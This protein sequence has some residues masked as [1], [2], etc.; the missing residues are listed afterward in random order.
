M[1][2]Y[3]HSKV[4]F[5]R[6]RKL[7]LLIAWVLP[8]L[9][10]AQSNAPK[11]GAQ[12]AGPSPAAGVMAGQSANLFP[13]NFSGEKT[14][15]L[16]N[17][18]DGVDAA[19][20]LHVFE[21]NVT[22]LNDV[23]RMVGT[24][25]PPSPNFVD[26]NGDSLKDLVVSDM[27]GFLWIYLNSGEKGKP[28]FTTGTFM[29]TYLG[30]GS[31]IHVCD[32][33]GDGDMDVLIGTAGGSIV[34]LENQGSNM[35]WKFTQSMGIPRYGG[36]GKN[37]LP[38]LQMGKKAMILGNNLAPWVTDWNKDGKPDLLV[39]DGTYSANS[40]RL[41]LNN[42]SRG[43]PIF[44]EDR[45]FY[46]AYGE[47]T[48]QLTPVVVDYNGDGL[49]D[50]IVGTRTGQI[51]LHK[52]TKKAMEVGAMVVALR[53]TTATPAVLEFDGL[54]KIG[55]KEVFSAMSFLYPCDWNDDG[56]FDLLLGSVNGK[57]YIALNKG[58][59]TEPNFPKA[60]SIKGTDTEKDML[61]PAGYTV[62]GGGCNSAFLLSAEK[63]L[64]LR[65]GSEPI[66]PKAGNYFAYF[67]YIH[68]YPG[69]NG[70]KIGARTIYVA[71]HGNIVKMKLGCSYEFSLSAILIGGPVRW[72]MAS[73][74]LV[75]EAT[76]EHDAQSAGR[77]VSGTITPSG[78]WQ[79]Q[80]YRFKAPQQWTTNL[81]YN[82]SFQLP[83][84][85]VNFMLDDLSFKEISR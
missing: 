8:W 7:L 30:S 68:D 35:K 50:L 44:L 19:G 9:V 38:A 76:E 60:E 23:G 26:M 75:S 14:V 64:V 12:A 77:G 82:L 48:E 80:S 24:R 33:D 81:F 28:K 2:A 40:V 5:I 10:C 69:W 63:E 3:I 6:T 74:E 52:G 66:R 57:I 43:R 49:P 11:T 29:H 41:L 22:V 56:L 25:M 42:G 31:K 71:N 84:G 27:R 18:W 54:V 32:W 37:S 73:S 39:G 45:M 51:R 13:D 46:L 58:S 55:G 21:G 15:K 85:D 47:G 78:S 61:A 83:E 67:R 16:A 53:G 72:S 1:R 65:A 34:L 79:K 20:D 62:H 36:A 4:N 17:Y 70:D 59:K